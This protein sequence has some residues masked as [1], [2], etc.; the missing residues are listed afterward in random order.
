MRLIDRIISGSATRAE[1]NGLTHLDA[2]GCTALAGLPE[3]PELTRLYARGCTALAGL[4]ELPELTR[5]DA[6]GCAAL[7]GLPE[8][9]KLRVLNAR[10][11][12]ALAGLPELPKLR[13]LNASGCTALAGLIADDGEHALVAHR[14]WY[15]AGCRAFESASDALDHWGPHRTDRRATLFRAAIISSPRGRGTPG[16]NG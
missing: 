10:G 2:S 6:R 14:E 5:L 4:P 3:L 16:A 13:V 12:T 1:L 8:L 7:A 11:C 9:P 15:L